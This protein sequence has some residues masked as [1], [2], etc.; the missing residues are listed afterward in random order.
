MNPI[1]N[2]DH[3]SR[4]LVVGTSG[5]GK[6]TLARKI[7]LTLGIKDIELDALHWGPD[8]TETPLEIFEGMVRREIRENRGFV[9]H[10][11]YTKI[12]GITWGSV[13][14]VVWLD[15]T[16]TVVM[17]RVLTRTLRRIIAKEKLWAGNVE[18]FRKS[19]LG[20]D[21]IIAWAW[22]TYARRKVASTF[23]RTFIGKPSS[24]SR[25]CL[26]YLVADFSFE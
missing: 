23:F 25:L 9:I 7:A 11:N 14:T 12:Q 6:S 15:Y 21:S 5:A 17:W 26:D 1:K 13:D 3:N 4:I 8:W 19:F 24:S 22:N 2:F 18:T 20:K 16:K 10:G